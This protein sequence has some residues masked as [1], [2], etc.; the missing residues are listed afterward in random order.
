VSGL[1]AA[2]AL[3]SGGLCVTV[4]EARPRIG[5]AC[6]QRPLFLARSLCLVWATWAGG[7][8]TWRRCGEVGGCGPCGYALHLNGQ[9]L[10]LG[11]QHPHLQL[12]VPCPLPQFLCSVASISAIDDTL[13]PLAAPPPSPLSPPRPP[14]RSRR[15]SLRSR[16]HGHLHVR[17]PRGAWSPVHPRAVKAQRGPEPRVVPGAAAGLA[18]RPLPE[19]RCVLGAH[20]VVCGARWAPAM[21]LAMAL[22]ALCGSGACNCM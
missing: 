11:A 15:P 7:W 9:R 21:A 19:P 2:K 12:A 18:H 14:H 13:T 17:V 4:V 10:S 16:A 22:G 6:T 8:G 5:G 3:A 20:A 1:S